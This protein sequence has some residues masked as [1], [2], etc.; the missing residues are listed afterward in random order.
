MNQ[1]QD[2][3]LPSTTSPLESN[4]KY[5]FKPIYKFLLIIIVPILIIT[6]ITLFTI[7]YNQG[8]TSQSATRKL[9]RENYRI[10]D[11]GI[12]K[13]G[14]SGDENIINLYRKI[15]NFETPYNCGFNLEFKKR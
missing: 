15:G 13:A 5:T 11:Y 9:I 14:I 10:D 12:V 1:L 8:W 7:D 4:N 6:S 3:D 2:P